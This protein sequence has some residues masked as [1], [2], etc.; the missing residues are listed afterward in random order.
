MA[1]YY[2]FIAF[3]YP[4]RRLLV[5]VYIRTMLAL[6]HVTG[7]EA[8]T[9][10]TPLDEVG[11]LSFWGVPEIDVER[12]TLTV[13]GAVSE[14]TMLRLEQVLA[15]PAV[16]RRVRMDCVGGFRNNI[17]VSGVRFADLM[18]RVRP[19]TDARRAIFYCADGYFESSTLSDLEAADALLVHTVNGERVARLGYP[20]RISIPG[21]YGYKWAKWVQRIEIVTHDRKGYWPQRGL[22][23][24]ANIGDLR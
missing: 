18:E 3:P 11:T 1:A 15:M 22:P 10:L 6:K 13:D 9:G 2:L 24:R 8:Q 5:A 21:K 17:D 20:L 4:A 14:P 19:R 16:E 12:Y 23:D 7:I